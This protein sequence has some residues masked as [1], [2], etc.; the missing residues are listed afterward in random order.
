MVTKE[1]AR[2][3]GGDGI[4]VSTQDPIAGYQE[5]VAAG[6]TNAAD[7]KAAR[8]SA[9]EVFRKEFGARCKQARGGL[10]TGDAAKLLGVHRNT[11]WNIER[12][13]SLPDAFDLELMARAYKTTVGFLATGKVDDAKPSAEH[14]S[15][16]LR[17]VVASVI[18]ALDDQ[19]LKLPVEKVAQLVDLIY[20]HEVSQAA[21]SAH[22]G[23]KRT[24]T[25]FLRLVAA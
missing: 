14:N 22:T 7:L 23:V 13:D 9:R 24:T 5:L 10:E 15:Q 6:D 17:E 20:E 3:G 21:T 1:T 4:A 25:R 19:Q 8:A 18:G 11:I 12:G 2:R 16:L